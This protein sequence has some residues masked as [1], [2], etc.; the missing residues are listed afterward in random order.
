MTTVN[1]RRGF[2]SPGFDQG[3]PSEYDLACDAATAAIK[4]A[5]DECGEV[6]FPLYEEEAKKLGMAAVDAIKALGQST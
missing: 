6:P 2:S 1:L 5:W 4:K 3:K